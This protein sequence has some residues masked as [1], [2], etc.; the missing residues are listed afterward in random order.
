MPVVETVLTKQ[1]L[2][3]NVV[4]RQ[5]EFAE[6]DGRIEKTEEALNDKKVGAALICITHF[7]MVDRA[8]LFFLP[9]QVA[10]YTRQ[11]LNYNITANF[12]LALAASQPT[13]KPHVRRYFCAAVQLPS[14]WLEVVR[15][16]CTVSISE[17]LLRSLP[18]CLK[19]AMADKFKQ[20]SEYQ[21]AKYNT[22]KH[23]CKHRGNRHKGEV[24]KL[25]HF[26]KCPVIDDL[27]M[28]LSIFILIEKLSSHWSAPRCVL[29]LHCL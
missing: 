16:Y 24:Q 4:F 13:T 25:C 22:R 2:E 1:E 10:V 14:D 26:P 3:K 7:S 11:K 15:I 20:F 23:R 6:F 17:Q 21:L 9:I 29:L 5:E 18:T 28:V 8:C 19:K 27:K 12:L